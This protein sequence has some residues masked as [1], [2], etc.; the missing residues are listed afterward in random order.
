MNRKYFN[1]L[2]KLRKY[3]KCM[4]C[5]NDIYVLGNKGSLNTRRSINGTRIFMTCSKRCSRIYAKR[6]KK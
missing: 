1:K 6:N 3:K 5:S 2:L 4:I